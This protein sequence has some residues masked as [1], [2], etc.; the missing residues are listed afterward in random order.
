MLNIHY[1]V[2]THFEELLKGPFLKCLCQGYSVLE[3]I[4]P[5]AVSL[6]NRLGSSHALGIASLQIELYQKIA[7]DSLML[8]HC[9][10][11]LVL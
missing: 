1:Q 11:R 6:F 8:S 9:I 10:E 7:V 2:S 5:D 3:I 4:N